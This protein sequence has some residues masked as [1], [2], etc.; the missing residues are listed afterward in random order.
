MRSGC[1]P[2]RE[3]DVVV[4]SATLSPAL[5]RLDDQVG[6]IDQVAQFEQVVGNPEIAVVPR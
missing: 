4:Q 1:R 2:R 3:V 5:C 6:D